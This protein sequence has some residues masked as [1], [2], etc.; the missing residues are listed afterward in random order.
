MVPLCD[1]CHE[2]L[3]WVA[4]ELEV[5]ATSEERREWYAR[6]CRGDCDVLLCFACAPTEWD[7][8]MKELRSPGCPKCWGEMEMFPTTGWLNSSFGRAPL[9]HL[10]R[11]TPPCALAPFSLG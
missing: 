1:R 5:A 3:D 2:Q 9:P 8:E 4:T 10:P 7:E 11:L 6:F